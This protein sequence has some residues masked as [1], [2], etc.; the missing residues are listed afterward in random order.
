MSPTRVTTTVARRRT[1]RDKT[2]GHINRPKTGWSCP[3]A[4][5]AC[6]NQTLPTKAAAA[7]TVLYITWSNYLYTNICKHIIHC[8]V[9]D[10]DKTSVSTY[11][12]LHR[13]C[14]HKICVALTQKT[15][16]RWWNR[17]NS[18]IFICFQKCLPFQ[19]NVGRPKT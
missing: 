8:A 7:I 3:G 9:H 15:H 16:F 14:L 6:R 13:A 11:I 2:I 4:V 18:F 1:E 19:I 5:H 12:I 17:K 10:P